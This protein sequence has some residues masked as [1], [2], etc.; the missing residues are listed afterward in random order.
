[1]KTGYPT[2]YQRC[3]SSN[4]HSCKVTLS[5]ALSLRLESYRDAF[6]LATSA[7]FL[8]QRSIDTTISPIDP[9]I[10]DLFNPVNENATIS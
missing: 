4:D 6:S 7:N 10:F 3:S 2:M 1:M 8:V 9:I 5:S